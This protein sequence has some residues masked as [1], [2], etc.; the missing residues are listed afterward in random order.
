[1]VVT[2]KKHVRSVEDFTWAARFDKPRIAGSVRAGNHGATTGAKRARKNGDEV[3]MTVELAGTR[4]TAWSSAADLRR[5]EQ[6]TG[7]GV[8]WCQNTWSRGPASTISPCDMTAIRSQ[9]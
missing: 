5:R 2:P 4:R 1:M 3:S 9:R 7:V 6:V 8:A